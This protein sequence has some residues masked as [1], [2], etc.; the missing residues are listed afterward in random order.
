MAKNAFIDWDTTASNNT[1]IGGIGILGSNAVKNFDDAFRTL[2]A[3]LRRDIDNGAVYDA[4]A[5]NYTAVANDNNAVHRFTANATLTLTAAATLAADWHYTVIADGG[6]VTIDPNASETIDGATTLIVPN[7]TTAYIICS[8]TAFF[9]KKTLS[10]LQPAATIASATTTDLGTVGSQNVTVTGTTTITGLGT[11]A[12]GMF[13]RLRF[14]G[15]LTL[16]HNGTSLILP[17]AVNI[18]TAAGDIAEFISEGSGNWRC[19]NYQKASLTVN[20]GVEELIYKGTG[21]GTEF[22]LTGLSAYRIILMRG[23][24]LPASDAEIRLRTSTNNGSSYDAGATDYGYNYFFSAG[25]GSTGNAGSNGAYIPVSVLNQ[26]GNAANEGI[27]LDAALYRFNEAA[28]MRYRIGMEYDSTVTSLVQ[29]TITGRRNSATARD[30]LQ[31]TASTGNVAWDMY[32]T[33]IRS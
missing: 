23:F 15:I 17:G 2:M 14:A 30:A 10:P 6:D 19:V 24:I 28:F 13:R 25:P 32:V 33:G 16:T 29:A 21:S 1:D 27:S 4:K 20:R 26:V 11:V 12:A 22:A 31:F 8:G 5:G 18:T 7:G 3:Q 9:S